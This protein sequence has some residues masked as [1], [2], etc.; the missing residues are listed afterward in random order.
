MPPRF[1]DVRVCSYWNHQLP[2]HWQS[3]GWIQQK[4][5]AQEAKAARRTAW[6]RST[7]NG[8]MAAERRNDP[9]T[10]QTFNTYE[11]RIVRLLVEELGLRIAAAGIDPVAF[12]NKTTELS[13]RLPD[14]DSDC[15]PRECECK[16]FG[17]T[18]TQE[19]EPAFTFR[20]LKPSPRPVPVAAKETE[21]RAVVTEEPKPQVRPV[22]V[23]VPMAAKETEPRAVVPRPTMTACS[24]NSEVI[25]AGDVPAGV[26]LR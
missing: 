21:P 3:D 11:Q 23:P 4:K 6:I 19:Q 13:L 2:S 26:W 20:L 24:T 8:W 9:L 16:R 12:R 14:D 25:F 18:P 22:P 10:I 5:E 17:V 1:P 15:S 7:I